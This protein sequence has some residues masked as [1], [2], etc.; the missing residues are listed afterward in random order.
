MTLKYIAR[1]YL[2]NKALS[3]VSLTSQELNTLY[4]VHINSGRNFAYLRRTMM[5]NKI[6]KTESFTRKYLRQLLAKEY[7]SRKGYNYTVT[8]KGITALQD[9]EKR[10]R[11]NRL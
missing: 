4:T 2:L 5:N 6:T 11:D 10:L 1:V 3:K 9:V 8:A 7:I